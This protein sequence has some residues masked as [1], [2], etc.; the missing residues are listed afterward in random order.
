MQNWFKQKC[1]NNLTLTETVS[2]AIFTTLPMHFMLNSKSLPSWEIQFHVG[3]FTRFEI[4]SRK[5][6][7]TALGV[8]LGSN[9]K[10]N[11]RLLWVDW[12]VSYAG[13][14]WAIFHE[15]FH[16]ESKSVLKRT[17]SR[18]GRKPFFPDPDKK[19]NSPRDDVIF[20]K[21]F[22]IRQFPIPSIKKKYPILF[23]KV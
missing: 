18:A 8:N 4:F 14:P 11:S 23:C 16:F 13:R 7:W 5:Y 19:L 10:Y 15:N 12:Y 22:W 1:Q 17:F 21:H 2:I 20:H 3:W 9:I 6:P